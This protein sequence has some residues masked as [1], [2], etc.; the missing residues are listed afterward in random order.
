MRRSFPS[1]ISTRRPISRRCGS[2]GRRSPRRSAASSATT[3]HAGC[4]GRRTRRGMLVAL[5][6][7]P[8]RSWDL[9]AVHRMLVGGWRNSPAAIWANC[10]G[11]DNASAPEA[12]DGGAG[13]VQRRGRD[14]RRGRT[15]PF[16]GPPVTGV[17]GGRM[18]G[19]TGS[20]RS[21]CPAGR[22]VLPASAGGGARRRRPDDVTATFIGDGPLRVGRRIAVRRTRT[23]R[24]ADR[25]R[26]RRSADRRVHRSA[27]GRTQPRR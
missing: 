23:R 16:V 14:G 21:P 11:L 10:H 13:P 8:A 12:S 7:R 25:S 24:T 6:V 22:R 9:G 1:T 19:D 5:G 18:A 27:A 3:R 15:R 2:T 4:G 17:A 20:H 26:R